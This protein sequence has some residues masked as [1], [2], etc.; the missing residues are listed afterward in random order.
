MVV[1]QIRPGTSCSFPIKPAAKG[2][3]LPREIEK[4]DRRRGGGPDTLINGFIV[5]GNKKCFGGTV[6]I[7]K[8]RDLRGGEKRFV[9][10]TETAL[11]R[12]FKGGG[13]RVLAAPGLRLGEIKARLFVL[14]PEVREKIKAILLKP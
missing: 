6:L 11:L 3:E 10:E 2:K 5:W 1:D 13:K 4:E 9:C 7:T 8:T 14:L 12:V